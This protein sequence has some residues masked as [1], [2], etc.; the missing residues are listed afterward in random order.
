VAYSFETGGI[1]EHTTRS[2]DL[3]QTH[4]HLSQGRTNLDGHNF[5]TIAR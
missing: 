5:K 2:S 3:L 4:Y 1:K